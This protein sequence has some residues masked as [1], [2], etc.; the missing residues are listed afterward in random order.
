MKNYSK[1]IIAGGI[2][3]ALVL[4][5][6]FFYKQATYTEVKENIQLLA[7]T[8]FLD[9]L[10][11]LPEAILL[12]VRT[13]QEYNAGHIAGALNVD[14]EAETFVDEVKKLDT[15][16][17]YF[18]YC[19]SGNRS[20]QAVSQMKALGFKNIIELKGGIIASPELLAADLGKEV[21]F[22]VGDVKNQGLLLNN[23]DSVLLT[24]EEKQ[25]LVYMREEEKLARDLY[26][27][28]Y[29]K[30]S[31]QIFSNIS[32]SEQT[33]TNAVKDLLGLYAVADPVKVDEKGVFSNQDLQK[34]YNDLLAK[35]SVSVEEALVVGATVEDLD[36]A[37]LQ[38]YLSKTNNS[39]IKLVYEN[40]MKG[41]RNHL[42]SFNSQLVSVGV[43]YQPSY[44]TLGEFTDII[45]SPKET[46]G[47]Q[48]K[49]RRMSR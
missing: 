23:Q 18:V 42:R 19:R 33:H 44:I 26:S 30:W 37:D 40:L 36:I 20:A 49:G 11:S 48:G 35:G 1:Y 10:R 9:A 4:S 21:S 29:E 45:N 12:D 3:I 6:W 24:E 32:S 15:G 8:Q 14:Y 13:P 25:G 31:M 17:T 28:L 43:K 16:K 41:S 46:G 7:G 2:A 22:D 34:V 38:R 27:K 39:N 5:G 47:M